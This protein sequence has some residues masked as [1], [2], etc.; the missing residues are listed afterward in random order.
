[1]QDRGL[2]NFLR[3]GNAHSSQ[4]ECQARIHDVHSARE[5]ATCQLTSTAPS[6]TSQCAHAGGVSARETAGTN[7]G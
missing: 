4:F 1:M 2:I 7:A 3:A 5:T 6:T